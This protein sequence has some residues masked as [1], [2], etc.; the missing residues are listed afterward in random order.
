MRIFFSYG[1]DGNEPLVWQIKEDLERRGH[2]VWFDK[3]EIKAGDDW[4]RSISEGI[5]KSD[6]VLAFL[7]AHAIRDPGVCLDEIAIAQSVTTVRLYTA[8]VEDE[9]AVQVP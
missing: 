2:V 4:R 6:A 1:H 8:L 5:A 9:S 3:A 7:S